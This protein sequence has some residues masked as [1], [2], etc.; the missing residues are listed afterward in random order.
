[1]SNTCIVLRDLENTIQFV[2]NFLSCPTS[3]NQIDINA[4]IN[5]IEL[6]SGAVRDLP[7][8]AGIKM[9]MLHRLHQAQLILQANRAGAL[10]T[11]LT[12][13]QILQVVVLKVTNHPVPCVQGQT[14]AAPSNCFSTSCQCCR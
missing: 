5:Q 4:L 1:M 8:A 10:N 12:V 11:L 14:I 3:L 6:V 7:L 13:L 9:D 2:T